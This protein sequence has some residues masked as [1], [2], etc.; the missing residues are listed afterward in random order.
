LILERVT[1]Q[2]TEKHGT[3]RCR[4]GQDKEEYRRQKTAVGQGLECWNIGIKEEWSNG[5][6]EYWSDG[7]IGRRI[8]EPGRWGLNARKTGRVS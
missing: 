8:L 2:K 1:G 3:Q 4:E 5:M 7:R 6:L